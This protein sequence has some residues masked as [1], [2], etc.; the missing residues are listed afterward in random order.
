M[1]D[2]IAPPD[3]SPQ[4][5]NPDAPA[6]P[7]APVAQP[8]AVAIPGTDSISQEYSDKVSRRDVPD[9]MKFAA[10]NVGTPAGDAA[11]HAIDKIVPAQ[12]QFK[13]IIV[14]PLESAKTPQEQNIKAAEIY[15][16]VA[17]APQWGTALIRYLMGDKQGAANLVTGG[18]P[19]TTTTYDIN[20]KGIKTVTNALGETLSRTDMED[21]HSVSDS[22]FSKRGGT[23]NSVA[24]T[25]RG[26]N[27]AAIAA[28]NV[29]DLAKGVAK[30]GKFAAANNG[31]AQQRALL[32]QD[33]AQVKKY[34]PNA[35]VLTNALGIISKTYGTASSTRASKSDTGQTTNST[36]TSDKTSTG[37]KAGGALGNSESGPG[38][39]AV[40]GTS[41]TEAGKNGAYV[42]SKI[43]TQSNGTESEN[44][45]SIQTA[46]NELMKEATAKRMQKG[47]LDR[48]LNIF[49]N[50][51]S[52]EANNKAL[53]ESGNVPSFITIPSDNQASNGI[54][55][56][57]VK[58]EHYKLNDALTAGYQRYYD[59]QKKNH[60]DPE[61]VPSSGQLEAAYSR[62]P[63]FKALQ[64][65][66]LKT[67]SGLFKQDDTQP[68]QQV[69]PNV[70]PA[71]KQ[72]GPKGSVAPS[73]RTV[74]PP[75]KQAIADYFGS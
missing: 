16:T 47:D 21:G 35:S 68:V 71:I 31:Q 25:L 33:L 34:D 43:G 41:G 24:E 63:E 50:Y 72:T 22:E 30:F 19:T 7:D 74:T 55:G 67:V 48:Y 20:G 66:Y 61:D 12:Q 10:R 15:K 2:P 56:L 59:E 38:N 49:D 58:N 64:A 60:V 8:T 14:D 62:T 18:S 69:K 53:R 57:Q 28:V 46:R 11:S 37:F 5:V 73:H 65:N 26:K 32:D 9:L 40:G 42:E 54:T 6:I 3:V 17:D 39:L 51:A 29:D 27:A 75:K 1:A 52:I 44:T 45:N 36:G 13:K 23:Y 70:P 4:A